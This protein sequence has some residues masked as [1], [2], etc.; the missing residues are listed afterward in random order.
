MLIK[1][2][3]LT[4]VHDVL[5]N[6]SDEAISDMQAFG[7]TLD[8]LVNKAVDAYPFAW[9]IHVDAPKCICWYNVRGNKAITSMFYTKDFLGNK[10]ITE[11]VKQIVDSNVDIAKGGGIEVIEVHSTLSHPLSDGW[12]QRLGFNKTDRTYPLNG[13]TITIFERRL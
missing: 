5:A 2:L 11:A 6:P 3:S 7:S 12:Y 9:T 13:R 8:S 1:S 10:G 4:D